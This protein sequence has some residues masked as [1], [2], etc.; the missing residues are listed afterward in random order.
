V[1]TGA[2]K[3]GHRPAVGSAPAAAGRRGAAPHHVV[4]HGRQ[5][6]RRPSRHHQARQVLEHRGRVERRGEQPA[7]LGEQ[8][9]ARLGRLGALARPP[10]VLLQHARVEQVLDAQQHLGGVERLGDEVA[11]ASASAYSLAS[12]VTSAVS[13]STGR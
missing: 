12:P 10:L 9:R 5:A 3:R 8:R 7:P 13:T 2:S 6:R 11:R 1:T 4:A